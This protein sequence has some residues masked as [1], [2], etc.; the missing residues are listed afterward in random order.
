MQKSM[1]NDIWLSYRLDATRLK[2]FRE[3]F[4]REELSYRIATGA[5]V[6]LFFAALAWFLLSYGDIKSSL[7]VIA[8]EV[9]MLYLMDQMRSRSFGQNFLFSGE[10]HHRSDRFLVFKN[11]LKDKDIGISEIKS[12]MNLLDS[13]IELAASGSGNGRKVAQFGVPLLVGLMVGIATSI[14]D[15]RIVLMAFW[16][17]FGVFIIAYLF[18][19]TFRTHEESL[20]EMKTFIELYLVESSDI[21]RQAS[22]DQLGTGNQQALNTLEATELDT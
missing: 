20:R 19:S 2:L 17:S 6:F 5:S 8:S 3:I 13:E 10:T 22:G 11:N 9:L 16:I 12:H 4:Q 14:N 15:I 18:A 7:A 1:W 21:G